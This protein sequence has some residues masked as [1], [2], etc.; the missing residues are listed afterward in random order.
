MNN[1]DSVNPSNQMLTNVDNLAVIVD[2]DKS[3]NGNC[4]IES[5]NSENSENEKEQVYDYDEIEKYYHKNGQECTEY[6]LN[7][8]KALQIL[9]ERVFHL[10]CDSS[11]PD[12]MRKDTVGQGQ[13]EYK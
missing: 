6:A 10:M 13:K 11:Y 1:K 3:K 5:G 9:K 2:V 8:F 12:L 7:N 4:F